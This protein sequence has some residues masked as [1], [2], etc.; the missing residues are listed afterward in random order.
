[1]PG[2]DE[3]PVISLGL[4]SEPKRAQSRVALAQSIGLQPIV[5]DRT[6]AGNPASA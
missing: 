5:Y 3:A 1:M 4:F 6:R 2:P